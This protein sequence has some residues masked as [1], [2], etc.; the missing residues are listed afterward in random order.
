MLRR[1][2]IVVLCLLGVW[3]ARVDTAQAQTRLDPDAM[4]VALHTTTEEEAGFIDR[5]VDLAVAGTLPPSLVESTFLWAKRKPKR[6]FQ[7]FK[8]AMILR[9]AEAGVTL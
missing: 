3:L 2:S 4:R 1:A 9:A 8:R 5:V 7:Y 6:Q